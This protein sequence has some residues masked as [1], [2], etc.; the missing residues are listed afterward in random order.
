MEYILYDAIQLLFGVPAVYNIAC[1][2][3]Q[4][5]HWS[6]H[7]FFDSSRFTSVQVVKYICLKSHHA[8]KTNITYLFGAIIYFMWI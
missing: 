4:S 6:G 2:I 5:S 8:R 7:S 1:G 3:Q